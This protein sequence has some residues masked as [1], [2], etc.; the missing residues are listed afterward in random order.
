MAR[1]KIPPPDFEKWREV[2]DDFDADL[3]RFR[4]AVAAHTLG[5]M[6]S[7]LSIEGLID[8]ISETGLLIDSLRDLQRH[9]LIALSLRA[10]EEA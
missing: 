3:L 5:D 6:L 9:M 2:F 8:R 10:P 4:N 1:T 7:S